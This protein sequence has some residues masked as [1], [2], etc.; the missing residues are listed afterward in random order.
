MQYNLWYFPPKKSMGNSTNHSI[1]KAER[2]KW[3]SDVEP[4]SKKK[5][6]KKTNFYKPIK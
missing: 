1:S 5:S 2:Q 4:V 3:S 6:N